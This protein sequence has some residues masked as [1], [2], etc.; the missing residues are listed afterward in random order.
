M[1]CWIRYLPWV[2]GAYDELVVQFLYL[3]ENHLRG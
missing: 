3:V 1:S 2:V